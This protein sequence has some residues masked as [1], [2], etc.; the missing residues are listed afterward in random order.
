MPG[1]LPSVQTHSGWLGGAVGW[2]LLMGPDMSTSSPTAFLE[3]VRKS[4]LLGPA[5]LGQLNS[6]S[7]AQLADTH[8]LTSCLV[9][10]GFLTPYQVDQILGG[11]GAT[12]TIGPYQVI[13]KLEGS[14]AY[15]ARHRSR[16]GKYVVK[17]IFIAPTAPPFWDQLAREAGQAAT[18]H[19]PYLTTPVEAGIIADK[20]I[21][22]R[23]Y[24]DG[25]DL[26]SRVRDAGPFPFSQACELI[27]QAAEAMYFVH[28]HLLTHRRLRPANLILAE[29]RHSVGQG[30]ATNGSANGSP[31]TLKVVDLGL[32]SLP[33]DKKPLP[34]ASTTGG[35]DPAVCQDIRDLGRA[36]AFLLGLG[37]GARQT[38]GP[39]LPPVPPEVVAIVK[40]MQTTGID[41]GFR[42]LA[43]VV[44]VLGPWCPNPMPVPTKEDA[45][46]TMP[47]LEAF[48]GDV[49]ALSEEPAAPAPDVKI[50]EPSVPA[51]S[52]AASSVT[53]PSVVPPPM[54]SPAEIDPAH[55]LE[56]QSPPVQSPAAMEPP[57][58]VATA[59]A[60]PV[61][62]NLLLS[63]EPT[64]SSAS[65][66]P[67]PTNLTED[68]P[69][70]A[71][72]EPET[73]PPSV[74]LGPVILQ[75]STETATTPPAPVEAPLP[76]SIEAPST[77]HGEPGSLDFAHSSAAAEAATEHQGPLQVGVQRGPRRPGRRKRGAAFWTWVIIGLVVWMIAG[78]LAV[79]CYI[80][81]TAEPPAPPRPTPTRRVPRSAL[82]VPRDMAQRLDANRAVY[83]N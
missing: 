79:M 9:Q 4:Q 30:T 80:V 41:S 14:V 78:A 38:K 71:P 77:E 23:P 42:S 32:G 1:R 49:P 13:G 10:L 64:D 47:A 45:P 39:V 17:P 35:T 62:P 67:W 83:F 70:A 19:H 76:T 36:F 69:E 61:W 18:L 65:S 24:V 33:S 48:L 22:A 3:L 15:L 59:P 72:Q 56:T 37:A 44:D 21:Y 75:A 57:M 27:R 46:E 16:S 52:A 55:L 51:P 82:G 8:S 11:Q 68:R 66:D 40:D 50:Q 43:E 25:K 2:L 20:P 6:L 29:P 58:E 12:L 63:D 73:I 34:P 60:P 26:A 81:F 74:S 7:G 28:A 5:Q 54:E 53:E 31:G